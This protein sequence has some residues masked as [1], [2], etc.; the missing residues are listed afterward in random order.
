MSDLGDVKASSI[1]FTALDAEEPR[2]EVRCV[3]L[4][5]HH[6]TYTSTTRHN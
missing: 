6:I 3:F 5:M 1:E 4:T 2:S